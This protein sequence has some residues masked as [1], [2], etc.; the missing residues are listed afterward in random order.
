MKKLM[1]YFKIG[2]MEWSTTVKYCLIIGTIIGL[3]VG[4]HIIIKI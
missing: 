1:K 2:T 3:L 4:A